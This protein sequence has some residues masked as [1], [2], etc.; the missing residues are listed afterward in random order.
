M[1]GECEKCSESCLDCVCDKKSY[2]EFIEILH[3]LNKANIDYAKGKEVN[4]ILSRKYNKELEAVQNL[5]NSFEFV[6]NPILCK[7]LL[8]HPAPEIIRKIF[9]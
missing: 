4:I 5:I 3:K 9:S 6:K 7:K 8:T 1:S 2:L